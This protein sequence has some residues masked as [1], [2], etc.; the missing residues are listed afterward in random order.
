MRNQ[1]ATLFRALNTLGFLALGFVVAPVVSAQIN[2][3]VQTSS[4]GS[5]T[6][7]GQILDNSTVIG[8]WSLSSFTYSVVGGAPTLSVGAFTAAQEQNY[9]YGLPGISLS[10]SGSQISSFGYS[11]SASINPSYAGAFAV[12]GVTILG[13]NPTAGFYTGPNNAISSAY[14][15]GDLTFSGFS[16]T[17]TLS[18][19]AN[20]LTAADGLTFT[21]STDIGGYN[22]GDSGADWTPANLKWSLSSNA[23]DTMTFL[24]NYDGRESASEGSAFTFGIVALPEPS[25]MAFGAVGS[26]VLLLLRRQKR[27]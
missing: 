13:R 24:A 27:A 10:M 19:P 4:L 25:T 1:A 23:G 12:E 5:G 21:T 11:V 16:G 7:S 2:Y 8:I 26:L 3:N 9:S 17:A 20:N 22:R 6:A 14:P 15:A 18:D